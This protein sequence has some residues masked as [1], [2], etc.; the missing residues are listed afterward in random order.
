MHGYQTGPDVSGQVII[1]SLPGG[2]LIGSPPGPAI[3]NQ[4][5]ALSQRHRPYANRPCPTTMARFSPTVFQAGTQE[6][7]PVGNPCIAL[8]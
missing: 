1:Q 2:T 5:L 6:S 3:L 4:S 7:P 8:S